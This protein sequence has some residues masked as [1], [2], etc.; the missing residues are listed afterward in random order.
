MQPSKYI[1]LAEIQLK[2]EKLYQYMLF[3]KESEKDLIEKW[4]DILMLYRIINV[5]RK[6]SRTW[7]SYLTLWPFHLS[8]G[9]LVSVAIRN[10]VPSNWHKP[11]RG[12]IHM[13]S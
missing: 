11:M 12:H 6:K 13:N 5:K 2:Y 9:L 4:L 3:F 1:D 10:A 8:T 7:P